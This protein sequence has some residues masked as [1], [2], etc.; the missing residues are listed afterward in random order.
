MPRT[1]LGLPARPPVP[2]DAARDRQFWRGERR[3]AAV[4]WGRSLLVLG[5]LD[6]H[7]AESRATISWRALKVAGRVEGGR[8]CTSPSCGAIR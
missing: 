6:G 3:F 1:A 5:F 2:I 4:G 7:D 8:P